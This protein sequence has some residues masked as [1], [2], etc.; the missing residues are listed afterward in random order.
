M[1][2]H[3]CTICGNAV[4]P[5]NGDITIC[6][7]CSAPPEALGSQQADRTPLSD[8]P[9]QLKDVPLPAGERLEVRSD[10]QI[11]D[12]ILDTYE[13]K[14]IYTSGGMGL[15]YR[16]HHRGWGIDLALKSPRPEIFSRPGGAESFVREAK[17]WV[18]LGLHPHIVSCYYVRTI[19]AIPRVFAEFVEGGSLKDWIEAVHCSRDRRLYEGGKE[20]ALERI[21]DIAIQFAWGLAYAHEQGL[22]HQDVKPANVLLTP[23]GIAKVTDFGLARARAMLEDP[24]DAGDM[25]SPLVSFGGLT[26]AYCSPEQNARQPLSFKTDIWS[27]AVSLLEMFAGEVSWYSG[28][29]AGEA[30]E[31][32]LESGHPDPARIPMPTALADMLHGCFQYEPDKRPR[33]ML[34]VTGRLQSIYEQETGRTYSRQMPESLELRADSLNNKAL[35]LLDLGLTDEA[36]RALGQALNADPAHVHSTLNLDLLRWRS[37]KINDIELVKKLEK[38]RDLNLDAWQPQYVLGCVHIERG[39]Y[40]S[41]GQTL[42]NIPASQMQNEEVLD[43]RRQLLAIRSKEIRPIFTLPRFKDDQV[44]DY[45]PVDCLCISTDGKMVVTGDSDH[46]II[47]WNLADG[48]QIKSLLGH[49]K[50]IKSVSLSADQRL[51]LSSADN[52][53]L[54]QIE[55]GSVM[56]ETDLGH[57]PAALSRD[58]KYAL[59]AH[60][61]DCLLWRISDGKIIR[62]FRIPSGIVNAVCLSSNNHYAILAGDEGDSTIRLWDTHTQQCLRVLEGHADGITS[63]SLTRDN[64][65]LLSASWDNTLKVW[66]LATGNC[67]RTLKG[68]TGFVMAGAI[69]PLG[70][71][72]ISGSDDKTLRFWRIDTGQCFRTIKRS[73]E[74]DIHAID[75][76]QDGRLA[77]SSAGLPIVWQVDM[78]ADRISLPPL[79]SRVITS[80]I[81][82]SVQ[83]EVERILQRAEQSFVDGRFAD[84]VKL[85][86]QAR[87]K[88]GFE[89]EE[90]S[91]QLWGRLSGRLPHSG[92]RGAWEALSLGFDSDLDDVA[93]SRRN[94]VIISGEYANETW[95]IKS[96]KKIAEFGSKAELWNALGPLE[97][98]ECYEVHV[99]G[100][101][102][103]RTERDPD[104]PI[105]ELWDE[106]T[107]RCLRAFTGHTGGITRLIWSPDRRFILSG[108]RDRTVKMWE[109]ANGCCLR[110]MEG[111]LREIIGLSWSQDGR[112]ILSADPFAVREWSADSG[113]CLQLVKIDTFPAQHVCFGLDCNFAFCSVWDE[114][115]VWD[116]RRKERAFSLSKPREA[117]SADGDRD[118]SHIVYSESSKDGQYVLTHS[119][120]D[121]V[122]IWCLDWELEA[123]DLVDW[124]EVARPYLEVFITRH[125]AYAAELPQDRQPAEEEISLA[126]TRRGKPDWA[127]EDFQQLL[128]IL[129]CAGYGWLRPE[130][131]RRELEKMA[132]NL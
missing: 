28:V 67:L 125:T 39:D 44:I 59:I 46:R 70:R 26:P 69:D 50:E 7:A 107:N 15:V 22:V 51:L 103:P 63:L 47:I 81:L 65:L 109:A 93:F 43:A 130:G 80:D 84:S 91:L 18:D 13:V 29:A 21:L 64:G 33:D 20:E 90:R 123:Y 35:S 68:H 34:E 1:N 53:K 17:T 124:D 38:Q 108:S 52:T 89:R 127:E 19:D 31:E 16:V 55:S 24:S 27:W 49:S 36:E 42:E 112:R 12:I 2:T 101:K 100:Y 79:L 62:E 48:S 11:G 37:G 78:A 99:H 119:A 98:H 75:I 106:H 92:L 110:T 57:G 40:E 74:G 96:K 14:H 23:D 72:A 56:L 111:H 132:A 8:L 131:V 97:Q 121:L 88:P 82:Q 86:R 117:E 71:Y 10:W 102:L 66:E 30:L 54:W 128:Y 105:F 116:L 45:S 122:N 104:D 113:D 114:L 120:E 25:Q 77:I 129:S 76:R 58:G 3:Y 60:G 87:S 61:R 4:Q 73:D 95:D 5:V 115:Q 85:L 41:A 6:P 126:L 118:Y 94:E 32:Y 83:H 9:P